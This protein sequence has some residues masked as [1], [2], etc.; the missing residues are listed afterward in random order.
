MIELTLVVEDL[1]YTE[2]LD[3]Q[4]PII[5]KTMSE[6]GD[7]SGPLKLACNSP[8]ATT[9]IVKGILKVM[10][11]DQKE[12]LFCKIL[13]SNREKLMRKANEFAARYGVEGKVTGCT[14]T[15]R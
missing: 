8:E 13:N 12:K 7:I 3:K 2:L 14:A 15:K 11:R 4:M 10:S 6:N 1:E 5:F 9:K